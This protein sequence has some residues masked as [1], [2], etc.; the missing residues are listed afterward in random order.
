MKKR[1]LVISLVFNIIIFILVLLG[2]IFMFTGFQFMKDTSVLSDSG[3]SFLKY[4]TVDSNIFIGIAALLL[5]IYELLF[6]NKKIKEIPKYVYIIK[7]TGTVAV[8]LTF[9]VTLLYLAPSLGNKCWFLYQNSNLF[10]HL[11]VPILSFISFCFFEKIDLNIR[12]S[13]YGLSTMLVYGII[14]TINVFIHQENGKI[15]ME[16]DWYGFVQH[17]LKYA[18]IVFPIIIIFTYFI[19]FIIFR[20]NKDRKI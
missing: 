8:T 5:I 15:G 13:F 20:I 2:T 14:Y 9:L 1:S 12:K 17:G 6:L 3:L 18:F 11:I 16:Y 7:Y 10:F 4:Y 19:S